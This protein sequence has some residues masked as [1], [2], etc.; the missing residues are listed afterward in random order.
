MAEVPITINAVICDLYGRTISGPLKIVGSASITGLG[1]GGGPIIPP[2]AGS[3]GQPPSIWP[4]PGDP[5]FP[6]GGNKPG[7]IWGPN[8]PRPTPPIANA[9]GVGPNPNPPGWGDGPPDGVPPSNGDEAGTIVKAPPVGGGW[10]YSPEYG[11]G[12]YPMGGI[13]PKR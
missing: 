8:D 7:G 11:W 3:P 13:G 2:D 9:P 6:G 12:Y 5:D 10:A 4:G 1:V